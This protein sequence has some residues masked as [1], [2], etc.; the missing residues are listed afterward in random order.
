MGWISQSPEAWAGLVLLVALWAVIIHIAFSRRP[1]QRVEFFFRLL[2][3][4]PAD[5]SVAPHLD[6]TNRVSL[7]QEK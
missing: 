5:D 1:K 3:Q 7:K 4:L 2:E 6:E